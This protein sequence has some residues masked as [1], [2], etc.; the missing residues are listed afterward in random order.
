[1][2]VRILIS[3]GNTIQTKACVLSFVLFCA[4]LAPNF[5]S[6]EVGASVEGFP[7]AKSLKEVCLRLRQLLEVLIIFGYSLPIAAIEVGILLT[8]SRRI[9][10]KTN[11]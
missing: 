4:I 3:C 9:D 2:K 7:L 10:I 8:I 1:M 5:K 6:E 11:Y